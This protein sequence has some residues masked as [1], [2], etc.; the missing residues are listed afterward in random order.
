MRG[1]G[2][3]EDVFMCWLNDRKQKILSI[4]DEFIKKIFLEIHD[5]YVEEYVCHKK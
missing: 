5:E 4:D 1:E 3:R 2:V